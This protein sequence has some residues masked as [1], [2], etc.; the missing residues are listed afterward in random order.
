MGKD[1]RQT[2]TFCLTTTTTKLRV[3]ANFHPLL[4]RVLVLLGLHFWGFRKQSGGAAA[5]R[6]GGGGLGLPLLFL[7]LGLGFTLLSL[8]REEVLVRLLARERDPIR[9]PLHILAHG[10]GAVSRIAGRIVP[11]FLQHPQLLREVQ[12]QVFELAMLLVDFVAERQ[13]G[14]EAFFGRSHGRSQLAHFAD[15]GVVCGGDT[16]HF[17]LDGIE[18]IGKAANVV[19]AVLP[20][21]L[22]EGVIDLGIVEC[23]KAIE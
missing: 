5:D 13:V 16:L 21:E 23:D 22:E 2:S 8:G 18:L 19:F 4:L 20:T 17:A 15:D 11:V 1:H 9:D 7:G 10:P 3:G 6:V 14:Q 12:C